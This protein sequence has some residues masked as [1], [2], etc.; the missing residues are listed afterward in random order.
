MKDKTVSF[1]SQVKCRSFWFQKHYCAPK[2]GTCWC[3]WNSV[4]SP[5]SPVPQEPEK[6]QQ[7]NFSTGRLL[8]SQGNRAQLSDTSELMGNLVNI[9]Q[10]TP[11]FPE[12]STCHYY[13]F[14]EAFNS[15]KLVILDRKHI[16]LGNFQ[17]VKKISSSVGS[18]VVYS[19]RRVFACFT[20]QR[21]RTEDKEL[22]VFSQEAFP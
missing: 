16:V 8:R 13:E 11:F 21:T 4:C 22:C 6:Q 3:F 1:L 12:K 19:L 9:G 10:K 15:Y 18:L 2:V 17:T 5:S 14:T 7:P 20:A